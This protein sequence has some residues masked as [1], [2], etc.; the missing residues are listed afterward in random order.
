MPLFIRNV[1]TAFCVRIGIICN[2]RMLSGCVTIGIICNT[3]TLSG[4]VRIGSVKNTYERNRVGAN[5]MRI[6]QGLFVQ[7]GLWRLS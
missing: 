4:C 2:T 5:T 1:G 3:R 6:F 7:L